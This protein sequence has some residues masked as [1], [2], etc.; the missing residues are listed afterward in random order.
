MGT[1]RRNCARTGGILCGV[2]RHWFEQE[3]GKRDAEIAK[4]QAE[5]DETG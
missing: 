3:F 2:R 1:W 5:A 4:R